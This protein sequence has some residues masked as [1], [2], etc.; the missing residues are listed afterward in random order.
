MENLLILKSNILEYWITQLINR[1]FFISGEKKNHYLL[2]KPTKL[3]ITEKVIECLKERYNPKVEKGGL[4]LSEF[5]C[6]ERTLF[7]NYVRFVKNVSEN[8]RKYRPQSEIY[9]GIIETCFNGTLNKIYLPIHFHTHPR[10]YSEEVPY[11]YNFIK[12]YV[13]MCTSPKDKKNAT[14]KHVLPYLNK[15]II[16]NIPSILILVTKFNETFLGVYGGKVAPE[17]FTEYI[18]KLLGENVKE[19]EVLLKNSET[20]LEKAIGFFLTVFYEFTKMGYK[21]DISLFRALG[22]KASILRKQNNADH[23]YFT[24]ADN[25][26]AV[27]VIP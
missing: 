11:V 7:I 8:P 26:D 9:N 20:T 19:A 14:K 5:S 17:D 22:T 1:S 21:S 16:L 25:D 12:T 23:N 27:I 6:H 13:N 18:G 15:N 3:I 2:N 4:L 10:E 24:L